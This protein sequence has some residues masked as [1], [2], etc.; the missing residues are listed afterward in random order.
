MTRPTVPPAPIAATAVIPPH[1]GSGPLSPAQLRIAR[2][3]MALEQLAVL[4][5]D[6]E[7]SPAPVRQAA[8][9]VLAAV[10]ELQA[11]LARVLVPA[12]A[13][14]RRQAPHP[15]QSPALST[16]RPLPSAAQSARCHLEN[17]NAI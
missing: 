14:A 3:R 16:L 15:Q 1:A 7:A 8:C 17:E 2:A 11:G 4:V 5:E 10:V 9:T 12:A 6:L 13:M